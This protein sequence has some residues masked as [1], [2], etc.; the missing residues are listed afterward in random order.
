[1]IKYVRNRLEVLPNR[2]VLHPEDNTAIEYSL[3]EA[4]KEITRLKNERNSSLHSRGAKL[5]EIKEVILYATG[6]QH[7]RVHSFT[8][9]QKDIQRLLDHFNLRGA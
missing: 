9:G 8:A 6:N 3:E 1:M 2:E 7:V 4:K 5:L